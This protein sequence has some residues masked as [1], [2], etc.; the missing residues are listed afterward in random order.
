MSLGGSC[1]R[2]GSTRLS[3]A[4]GI[5][6]AKSDREQ[7]VRPRSTGRYTTVFFLSCRQGHIIS[8]FDPLFAARGRESQSQRPSPLSSTHYSL[9]VLVISTVVNVEDIRRAP[10]TR[11]PQ[12]SRQGGGPALSIPPYGPLAHCS[13][14]HSLHIFLVLVTLLQICRTDHDN[15]CLLYDNA[16]GRILRAMEYWLKWNQLA[17][18]QAQYRIQLETVRKFAL[19]LR[20]CPRR[21]S[22]SCSWCSRGHERNTTIPPLT[23]VLSE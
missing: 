21:Q 17:G 19:C 3:R 15:V 9:S 18:S 5:K 6:I 23:D 10:Q 4:A 16:D 13:Y 2:L 7:F 14:R 1:C 12:H 22:V 8:P 20:C 11:A